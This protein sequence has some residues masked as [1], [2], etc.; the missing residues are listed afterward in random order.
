MNLF[1]KKFMKVLQFKNK[2]IPLHRNQ[3]KR[4]LG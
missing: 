4:F 1:D 3:E 2:V